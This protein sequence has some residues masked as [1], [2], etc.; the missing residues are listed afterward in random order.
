MKK[1]NS[2]RIKLHQLVETGN[3]VSV[4]DLTLVV[5]SIFKALGLSQN[6]ATAAAKTVIYADIRGIDSHGVSTILPRYVNGFLAKSL[7]PNPNI[8][9]TRTTKTAAYIEADNALGGVVMPKAIDLAIEIGREYGVG[10]VAVRKAGHAGALG[11]HALRATENDMIGLVM[12]AGKGLMVPPFGRSPLL[13]TNPIAL[14]VP[15]KKMPTFVFDA[16][17]TTACGNKIRLA[18]ILKVSLPDGW[19]FK[20]NEKSDN[21]IPTYSED[22]LPPLLPLGSSYDLGAH[23]GFGFGMMAEIF[24]NTL[25]A[26]LSFVDLDPYA[27]GHFVAVFRV[28]TFG[29]IEDFKSRMDTLLQAVKNAPP[30]DEGGRVFYAGLRA[31]EMESHR[32]KYGIPL[33]PCVLEWFH[34][35]TAR[36]NL[37][38]NLPIPVC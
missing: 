3:R 25:A 24:C 33:Q 4:D 30:V 35:T 19:I 38:C 27:I 22:S 36:L 2:T 14:A 8:T 6:D 32:R 5:I 17:T 18:E 21:I 12:A 26:Q 29:S 34:E 1:N 13:G 37:P 31:H 16:A 10:I 11:C 23:K 15:T 9:V 28:D 7:N 20:E